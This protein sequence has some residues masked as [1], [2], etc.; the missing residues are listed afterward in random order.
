VK[1]ALISFSE[2]GVRGTQGEIQVK[3]GGFCRSLRER[4]VYFFYRKA[5]EG[6]RIPTLSGVLH[7]R[8]KKVIKEERKNGLQFLKGVIMRRGGIW[9]VTEGKG[10]A[11]LHAG[12]KRLVPLVR[13]RKTPETVESPREG[14][15]KRAGG[16]KSAKTR[17]CCELWEKSLCDYSVP[18]K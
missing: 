4:I 2:G 17:H 3:R 18:K 5:T 10:G 9:G 7:E 11:H 6:V 14:M 8:K 13:G 16:R 1:R 15:D 12:K